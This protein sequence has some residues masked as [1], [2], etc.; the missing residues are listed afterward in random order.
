MGQAAE[1]LSGTQSCQYTLRWLTHGKRGWS[2]A[3]EPQARSK[4]SFGPRAR[5]RLENLYLYNEIVIARVEWLRWIPY[6]KHCRRKLIG[7][8]DV[9]PEPRRVREDIQ[10]VSHEG[11]I[12]VGRN[13][14]VVRR[15]QFERLGRYV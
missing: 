2:V 6:R 8:C 11:R 13:V 3:I 9:T 15:A 14:S 1:L 10:G 7:P 4:T 5:I 12:Q